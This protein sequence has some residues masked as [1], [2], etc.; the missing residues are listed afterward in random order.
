MAEIILQPTQNKSTQFQDLPKELRLYIWKL[1]ASSTCQ[2]IQFPLL[3]PPP[4]PAVF[5][6]SKEAR[7]ES[8]PEYKELTIEQYRVFIRQGVFWLWRQH[9]PLGLQ[10]IRDTILQITPQFQKLAI[11]LDT[12]F[13]FC[14]NERDWTRRS[15]AWWDCL[16]N[17]KELA[18]ITGQTSCGRFQLVYPDGECKSL[19][20]PR[21]K[22]S[23]VLPYFTRNSKYPSLESLGITNGKEWVDLNQTAS[24]FLRKAWQRYLRCRRS[25]V[26]S[27]TLFELKGRKVPRVRYYELNEEKGGD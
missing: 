13:I 11:R 10:N 4:L 17:I 23:Q 16:Q 18:I 25:H 27:E 8:K 1:V 22:P 6:T 21:A 20:L 14:L 26:T 24:D 19:T 5:L 3:R 9:D 2:V 7:L 12:W 15:G